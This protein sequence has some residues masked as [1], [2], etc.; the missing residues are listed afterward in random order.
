[1][2]T[3]HFCEPC[4]E[5]SLQARY[6]QEERLQQPTTVSVLMVSERAR[7]NMNPSLTVEMSYCAV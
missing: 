4:L 1:M 5:T 2:R 3:V 7:V 6:G